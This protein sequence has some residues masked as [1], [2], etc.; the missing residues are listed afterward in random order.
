[1]HAE[2]SKNNLFC[3][4]L[5]SILNSQISINVFSYILTFHGAYAFDTPYQCHIYT[6]FFS[7]SSSPISHILSLLLWRTNLF[8]LTLTRAHSF[9]ILYHARLL[10]LSTEWF[11]PAA[12]NIGGNNFSNNLLKMCSWWWCDNWL[13]YRQQ[14]MIIHLK[15]KTT[16]RSRVFRN[17][18]PAPQEM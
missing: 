9:P 2:L 16:K 1:M 17:P 3:D 7:F 8:F 12:V 18:I 11:E 10:S 5:I 15:Q 14:N 4:S 13:L 6:F